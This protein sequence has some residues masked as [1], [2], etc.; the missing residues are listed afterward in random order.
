MHFL[1]TIYF[2]ALAAILGWGLRSS[3]LG[4]MRA[5]L[6]VFVLLWAVLIVTA[7]ILSL[8]SALNV[9][10]LYVLL[11]LAFAAGAG[12]GLQA[13]RP[14]REL[15]FPEF[16]SPFGPRT[17]KW[18]AAL[19]FLSGALVLIGNLELA[20][21]FLPANPDSIV[22]R[23][24]RVYWYF[25]HGSL[26]HFSNQGEPRPQFY[27]FNGAIAYFPLLHFQ[28]G[29]R[30]FSLMSL[31]CWLLAGLA[32]YVFSRDLGG[33]RLVAAANA[34]IILLTPNVLIQSLSTND[35]LIAAAPLLV[36]L[37]FLHRWFQ[38]RQPFDALV[39]VIGAAISAGTKL[40]IT[41]YT[42]LLVLIGLVFLYHHRTVSKEMRG[43]LSLRGLA[44]LA[45]LCAIVVV[46]SFS[47]TIYNYRATGQVM[48]WELAAQLQNK[49]FYLPAALQNIVLYAA[50]T[51]LTPIADLHIG[52]SIDTT[53]RAHHYEWFNGLFAPLFTWVNN[54][55]SFTSAG[56]RFT[57]VNSSQAILLNEQTV[58]IGFTW[59]LAVMS[60]LWLMQRW[61]DP[62]AWWARLHIASLPIWFAMYA[63]STR[64]IE[65]FSV[66]LA[67]ATIV[68]APAMVYAFAP[69]RTVWV[70]Q[71]RLVVLAM[72]ALSQAF[73][74]ANILC[75]SP[76]KNLLSLARTPVRPVSRGFL[77][78]QSISDEVG[79]AG[80]GVVQHAIAWGQPYWAFMA[81][82]PKI[83]QYL[84]SQPPLTVPPGEANDETSRALR[85]SRHV[86]MPLPDSSSLHIYSFPQFPAYSHAV[87]LR[88]PDKA[89]PGLT[90]IGDLLFAL[91]PEWV[92]AA[93]DGVE[94]R[95]PGRSKYVVVPYTELSDFG[96]NAEPI[97]RITPTIYGLGTKD[98]LK[99]R[100]EIRID[101]KL[102]SS[103]DWQA[104]P[105]ADL[106]TP[107][108]KPGNAVLT[109]YVRNDN[110]GGKVYS[111]ETVLQSTKPMQLS[112]SR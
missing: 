93:G 39:G 68:A 63:A 48:A 87:P 66:Y 20:K 23:F 8:F 99:F 69:I 71:L 9:T 40:H 109:M 24:P 47:F 55:P 72:I 42:P 11:S 77:V 49:P 86:L 21:G 45:V 112:S 16:A 37:L 32:T 33:S 50:Q 44:F 79:R 19:L 85:Y 83:K 36:G 103:T 67:Y 1:A 90:W 75:T 111:V 52:S 88:I 12:L 3:R 65:G 59:V 4:W 35:E 61:L 62:R 70:A 13:I 92:F 84:A 104:V 28:L 2:L 64:Y 27:P 82:H 57:G 108:I 15:L 102:V 34:W 107:G 43:W 31:A 38:A 91:G 76:A 7:Q 56:Y 58:F 53:Y 105:S 46:F 60:A 110:A 95:Y 41:F 74:A 10:W 89:S 100:F 29:P 18:I 98:D 17:A 6:A 94:A 14:A 5:I 101:G 30:S 106:A 54:G 80:N 78:D 73:F 51:V 26:A 96:R 81:Y 97:I 22:Y 25:S